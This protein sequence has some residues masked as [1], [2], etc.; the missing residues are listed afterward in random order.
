MKGE[1]TLN[2]TERHTTIS[3]LGFT[4]LDKDLPIIN[5]YQGVWSLTSGEGELPQNYWVVGIDGRGYPYTGH[6][7]PQQLLDLANQDGL[8]GAYAAPYGHYVEGQDDGIQLHEW[9]R[10]HRKKMH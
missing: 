10:E 3:E 2:R 8:N 1:K 9:I 7:S 4:V 6:S 5:A